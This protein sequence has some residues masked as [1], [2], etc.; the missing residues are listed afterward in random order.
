[1]E[2]QTEAHIQRWAEMDAATRAQRK[3]QCPKCDY[4]AN[5]PRAIGAH[6]S[7]VH[8]VLGK[9]ASSVFQRKRLAKRSE[10]QREADKR[11][12]E[13]KRNWYLQ[14]HEKVL[15]RHRER[16]ARKRGKLYVSGA[17]TSRTDNAV[18]RIERI[19]CFCPQCGANLRKIEAALT[20]GVHQ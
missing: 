3:L 8:G 13:Y 9:S 2:T 1:M 6:L 16:Y 11:R 12:A 17:E 20:G 10:A 19:L 4:R 18:E 7:K 15:K 5:D 14:N